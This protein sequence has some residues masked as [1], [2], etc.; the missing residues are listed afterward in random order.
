MPGSPLRPRGPP[1]RFTICCPDPAG[2]R[3]TP[4]VFAWLKPLWIFFLF[5]LL[6]N[7]LAAHVV[8]QFYGELRRTDDSWQLEILFDAGYAVEEWRND[9]DAPQPQ[10]QWLLDMPRDQ[11]ELLLSDAVNYLREL[12]GFASG[13]K[14]VSWS[15]SYPDFQTDPPDLPALLND[16]AYFHVLIEPTDRD[17]GNA[18]TL[19]LAAGEHPDLVLKLPGAGEDEFLVIRPRG[20]EELSPDRR[21]SGAAWAAFIQ[22]ILHV[23]PEGLDHILFVLGIF[24]LQRRWKPLIR[25]SLL[26]TAAHTLTLGLATAGIVNIPASIV[27]P[28]IALSIAALAIEI[29][30]VTEVKPWRHGWS[31]RSASFMASDSPGFSRPGSGRGMASSRHCSA[32]TR[33]L[34][35][36]KRRSLVPLGS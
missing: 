23:V 24:L 28:L 29:L 3:Q 34:K 30:F 26:F 9:A 13:G 25:Q 5:L 21:R 33:G 22:G 18:L 32:R 17:E 11:R 27:E 12:L 4:R 2:G 16:G 6:G 1:I 15:A 7:S 8:Q 36:P 19:S 35:S 10:R 31:S 20:S 14:T